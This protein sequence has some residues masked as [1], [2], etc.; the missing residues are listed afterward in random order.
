MVNPFSFT[1]LALLATSNARDVIGPAVTPAARRSD[2]L[3]SIC[4]LLPD[5][6]EP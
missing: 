3:T 1:V 6:V 5:H 2:A 4:D